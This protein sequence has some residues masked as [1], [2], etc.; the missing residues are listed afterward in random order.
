MA[1]VKRVHSY[2][3]VVCLTVGLLLATQIPL[4]AQSEPTLRPVSLP[5]VTP[6]STADAVAPYSSSADTKIDLADSSALPSVA[7]PLE[8]V[9]AIAPGPITTPVAGTSVESF[10]WEPALKQSLY[11]LLM[12]HAFRISSDSY[13]RYLLLHKPF[14][15]DYAASFKDTNM[16][17]WGD[18]DDFIVNY[19]GHPMQG[20]VTGYIEIQNDPKGRAAKFGKN[21]QYWMSRLRAMG[22]SAVYSSEFE[23][24]PILSETA[25]GNQGGYTYIP[26]CGLYPTCV[27]QPGVHYKPPTNNTG[28]VD[29]VVTPTLGT[30]WVVLEDFLEAKVT[31]KLADGRDTLKYRILRGSL[32]PARS[33]AN[34]LAGHAPWYRDSDK[35][36][37][38][39]VAIIESI[40]PAKQSRPEWMDEARKSIGFHVA[41]LSL[42]VEEGCKNCRTFLPGGGIDFSYRLSKLWYFDSEYDFFP[43]EGTAQEALFGLKFGKQ[44]GQ[45]G[46]F[47]QARPGL[48]HYGNAWDPQNQVYG[49]MNRFAL[50]LGGTAE[51]YMSPH[52]SLRF[53]AGTLFVR[54]LQDYP[55]PN[56]PPVSVLSKDFYTTQGNL[57][58]SS[59][60][61][62]RF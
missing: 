50:D 31:D 1:R 42:P 55:D 40:L 45:W 47:A 52:T 25:L 11:F 29:S 9:S 13:A 28:W 33:L 60:Y 39:R 34:V 38:M 51:Y 22:W 5:F 20:A 16:Q 62:Y 24:G 17:R 7:G 18:G 3:F 30:G 57:Y 23:F 8:P 44:L 32:S 48:I 35:G 58:V 19:I 26:H 36:R 49:T 56:Q 4:L 61:Q 2:R 41:G 21:R 15:H 14:W 12:E 59:G 46:L 37:Q 54:Y 6:A 10:H 27:K 53:K 43:G